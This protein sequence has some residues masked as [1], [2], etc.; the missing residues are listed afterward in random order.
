LA[1]PLVIPHIRNSF[2]HD[3][4]HTSSVSPTSATAYTSS[5]SDASTYH[6]FRSSM[7]SPP[8]RTSLSFDPS[9]SSSRRPLRQA[10][11]SPNTA[12]LNNSQPHLS[13]ST[14]RNADTAS[15]EPTPT[16]QFSF[17][18]TIRLVPS[19]PS[20]SPQSTSSRAPFQHALPPSTPSFIRDPSITPPASV[21]RGS[22][23][24]LAVLGLGLGME[25][26][27]NVNGEGSG[28]GGGGG[29]ADL[30]DEDK[31][32]EACRRILA[33]DKTFKW[34]KQGRVAELIGG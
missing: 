32:K 18:Q 28:G 25:S 2:S 30:S 1:L 20:T 17:N 16:D 26:S 12:T 13:I 6:S 14:S 19:S 31:G 27:E 11:S 23:P 29:G 24:E 7:D 8:A 5:P 3:P 34:V 21:R 15:G 22:G 10:F 4:S 9:S 33:G